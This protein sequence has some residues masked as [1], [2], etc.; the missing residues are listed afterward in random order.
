VGSTGV[1]YEG[2]TAE[3]LASLRHPAVRAVAPRFCLFDVYADV[4]FPGGLHNTWFTEAW[5][6]ANEALDRGDPGGAIAVIMTM[7]LEGAR[8]FGVAQRLAPL[9]ARPSAQAALRAALGRVLRGVA[10]VNGAHAA[11]AD[12]V[13]SHESNFNVHHAAVHMTFRDDIAP[14]APLA[15]RTPDDFSPHSVVD[16]VRGVPVLSYGGWFDGAY[17]NGALKRHRALAHDTGELL[18]GPWIH[19][20][21]VDMDPGGEPG[22]AGFDHATELLRFFDRHLSPRSAVAANADAP[23]VRYFLMGA[24]E[25]RSAATFPPEGTRALVLRFAPRRKLVAGD[26]NGAAA[27][28]DEHEATLS[29]GAGKRTRWRTL[30]CPFIHADGAGRSPHGYLVY[31]TAPFDRDLEVTGNPVLVLPLASS[32]PDGAVFAYLE[33]VD[34]SGAAHLFTEG[35]LRTVHAT[36]LVEDDRGGPPRVEATFRRADA[37]RA[38]AGDVALHA[39][40]L[41]PTAMLVRRG[42]RLRLSLGA[43]DVDHFATPPAPGGRVTWR[44][45]RA[46]ARLILPVRDG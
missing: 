29:S 35:L 24:R 2:T 1:S 36:R 15:G 34:A 3:F 9:L 6:A 30:L 11:V 31:E 39:I 45:D 19:G 38:A 46:G 8:D 4:A 14:N 7:R 40:E 17:A 10:P 37:V 21:G 20:G 16:Q 22:A 32:A 41:L 5:E 26:P 12:A 13:R 42:H 23:R 44:I 18:L 25:W 33:D 43:A 28:F 27:G